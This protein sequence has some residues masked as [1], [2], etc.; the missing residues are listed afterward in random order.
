MADE[1]EKLIPEAVKVL[2]GYK[3]VN[4]ALLGA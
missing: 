1:V 4:Y 2:F 3:H